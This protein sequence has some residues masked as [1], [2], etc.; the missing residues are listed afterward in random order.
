LIFGTGIDIA[1]VGRISRAVDTW[2]DRFLNRIWTA[3]E[4]DYCWRKKNPFE[5]LAGRFAAKEAVSKAL[6]LDWSKGLKW[7]E[8]EIINNQLGIPEV[9]LSG[10]AKRTAQKLKVRKILLSMSHCN[11]YAVASATIVG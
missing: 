1:Q 3:Q 5:H 11:D 9:G 7:R 6:G 8:I 10:E 2:G 4:I